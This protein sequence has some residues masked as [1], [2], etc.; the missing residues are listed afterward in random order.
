M[1]PEWLVTGVAVR[2]NLFEVLQ[3][4][5]R[6]DRMTFDDLLTLT[7]TVFSLYANGYDKFRITP[8]NMTD[9]EKVIAERYVTIAPVRILHFLFPD[10]IRPG[11]D[12]GTHQ[13]LVLFRTEVVSEFFHSVQTSRGT[14]LHVNY[15]QIGLETYLLHRMIHESRSKE[16][17]EYSDRMLRTCEAYRHGCPEFDLTD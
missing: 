9:E 12:V 3:R 15:A 1:K 14:A 13:G 17:V 6:N 10:E 4:I 16:I 7:R 8:D 5:N 2:A 11:L